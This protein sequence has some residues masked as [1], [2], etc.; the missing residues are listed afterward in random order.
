MRS[1]IGR[2]ITLALLSLFIS[3]QAE[4]GTSGPGYPANVYFM[5]N[6]IAL[7]PVDSAQIDPPACATVKSRFAI[8]GTTSA[9]KVQIA[10]LLTAIA[11]GKQINIWGTGTCSIW[12]DTETIS[13]FQIIS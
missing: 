9:G 1:H 5:I 12:G 13:F 6:G 10:A 2:L 3:G 8:D 7:I 4:A 11:M